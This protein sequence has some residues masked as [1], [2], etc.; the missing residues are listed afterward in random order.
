MKPS[1][2]RRPPLRRRRARPEPD[3]GVNGNTVRLQAVLTAAE[4]LRHTP[5]GLPVIEF[6]VSHAS[7]QTEAGHERQVSFEMAAKAAG[8]LAK[9]IAALPA[10]SVIRLEGFLNRRHR[11]S[12]QMVLHVTHIGTTNETNRD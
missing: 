5:A 7:Q 2:P 1:R 3:C 12:R 6:T 11:M 9:R 8:E 10:G 4:T